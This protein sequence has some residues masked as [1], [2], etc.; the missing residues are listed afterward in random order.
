MKCVSCNTEFVYVFDG[1]ERCADSEQ[2]ENALHIAFWGSYGEFIDILP[3]EDDIF[4]TICHDCAI[5]LCNQN[6]WIS[7]LLNPK[8]SHTHK[9]GETCNI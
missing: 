4:A 6:P 9:K 2:F 8:Y 7:K 3:G 5:T 1:K